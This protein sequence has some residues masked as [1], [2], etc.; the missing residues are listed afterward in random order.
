MSSAIFLD[1]DGVLNM[2]EIKNGRSY[3]PRTLEQFV[4][5]KEAKEALLSLKRAGFLLFVVT[6]QPDVGHGL[7]DMTIM[8]QMHEQ[9]FSE[10]L[11]DDL[12]ACYHRQDED[13]LCRKPRA[14]MLKALIGR[15]KVD[16]SRSYMVGD[17]WSDVT[18]GKMAGCKT[19]FIDYKYDEKMMDQPD[20]VVKTLV[21]AVNIIIQNTIQSGK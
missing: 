8:Q 21:Q 18:A 1:R 14:G 16:V 17:R 4:F 7:I 20:F 2:P 13:C 15:W 6:N 12:E 9:T 10:L 3:A 19:I 11:I 5:F